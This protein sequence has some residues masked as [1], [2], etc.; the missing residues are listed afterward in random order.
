[1][2]EHHLLVDECLLMIC[3]NES[4]LGCIRSTILWRHG[5]TTQ[6]TKTCFY[7]K[8]QKSFMNMIHFLFFVFFWL[9]HRSAR[10]YIQYRWW[11]Q[12]CYVL[13]ESNA[14]LRWLICS[15]VRGRGNCR[16]STFIIKPSTHKWYYILVIG[17]FR[18][19]DGGHNS[20][21][22]IN[23]AKHVALILIS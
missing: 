16:K 20:H 4:D 8:R 17:I 5:T 7:E 2:S 1:M 15:H 18:D 19:I 23:N 13:C 14:L 22:H 21:W 12:I 10:V 6:H 3:T 11:W 9:G